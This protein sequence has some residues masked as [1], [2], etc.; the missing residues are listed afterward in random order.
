MN[1]IKFRAYHIVDKKY[2]DLI[3]IDFEHGDCVLR[4]IGVHVVVPSK[5]LIL[6]QY[7]NLK[8]KK[9]VELYRGDMNSEGLFIT[10]CDR[11]GAWQFGT[12]D[13]DNKEI[14]TNCHWCEGDYHLQDVILDF[15]PSRRLN[16]V[17]YN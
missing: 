7:T 13:I 16:N 14:F 8:N 2:Y 3:G 11:C 9:G 4:I 10:W 15:E 12:Y 17:I 1:N 5:V 6:E